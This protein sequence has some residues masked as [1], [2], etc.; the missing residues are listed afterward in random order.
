LIGQSLSQSPAVDELEIT[1][2]GPGVGEC[3]LVHCGEGN[4]LCIDSAH[5]GTRCWAIGYLTQLG[6]QSADSLRLIVCTHWHTDHVRGLTE[7][8][9]TCANARFVCSLALRSEEFK[10]I[11]ARFSTTDVFGELSLPLREV[12]G[13]F[14]ILGSRSV[15]GGYIP[16]KLAQA[17]LPLDAFVVRGVPVKIQALSPS[18]QDV[19]KALQSFAGYFVPL[20]EGATGLSPIDQNDASVVVHIE[21]GN[22]CI[23]LGAD[24]EKT[25]SP[26][27]GWNAVVA[28]AM[29]PQQPAGAFKVA[30]HGSA[31]AHSTAVWT[32]MVAPQAIAVVTPY[33]RSA[34]PRPEDIERLRAQNATVF[35]TG[36]PRAVPMHRRPEVE[37]TMREAAPNLRTFRRPAQPGIVRLRKQIG[38]ARWRHEL[39]GAATAL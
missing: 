2:F 21:I 5:E 12:R 3:V 17:H 35:A 13:V 6:V 23:L 28:S 7:L 27:T 15:S 14:E 9:A 37:R 29:R 10:K 1:V 31:N 16:P 36:L 11:V 38:S 24:L 19:F 39:F 26:L 20:D 32:Q 25:N 34:L 33:L 18:D 4:W 30:H 8:V 22:D